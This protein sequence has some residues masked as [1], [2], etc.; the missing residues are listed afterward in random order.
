[1]MRQEPLVEIVSCARMA[2]RRQPYVGSE[3]VVEDQTSGGV[4]ERTS[5]ISR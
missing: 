5:P 4:R 1:M 3:C 2:D